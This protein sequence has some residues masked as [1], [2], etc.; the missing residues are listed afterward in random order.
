MALK[1]KSSFLG[2]VNKDAERQQKAASSYG[3]LSLPKGVSVFTPEP[4]SRNVMLDFL[5]YKVT[6]AKH[7][8]RNDE[9]DIATPGSLWY[10][11]PYKVHRNVGV[12]NDTVVCPTSFKKPCPICEHRAKRIKEGDADKEEL[13]SLKASWRNL[14]VVVPID[15]KK[16]EDKPHVFDISQFLF[17]EL[18][19]EELKENEE[20]GVFPDLEIGKTLKLRFDSSTIANSKPFAEASRIDF[21][22]RDEQYDEAILEVVP[23]LD[24]MLNVMSYKEIEAKF[25]EIEDEE[26]D[27]GKLKDEDDTDE[28][29]KTHRRT[30]YTKEKPHSKRKETEEEEEEEEEEKPMRKPKPP[31]GSVKSDDEVEEEEEE[32][33][34]AS[35]VHRAHKTETVKS[36]K[37]KCPHGHKFGVDTD[38]YD[39]CASCKSWDDCIEEKEKS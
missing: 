2:K 10:K 30:K 9:D 23:N 18:L 3:Y 33:K 13:K 11:R 24:N 17:Q 35:K 7:P 32:E 19:N 5:P 22:E 39:E 21:I 28:E 1:K 20:N 15:N 26:E 4:G 14:Y 6:D 29:E 12:D 8:D 25:F 27:G 16:F 38:E 34:P 36:G 37:E 31:K